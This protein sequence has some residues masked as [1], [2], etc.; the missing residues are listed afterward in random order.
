MGTASANA[1][2][3]RRP[4]VKRTIS[5]GGVCHSIQYSRV[6]EEGKALCEREGDTCG[7]YS[8]GSLCLE[9]RSR[10]CVISSRRHPRSAGTGTSVRGEI[11]RC[12]N[13]GT[14]NKLD[15]AGRR[16][17]VKRTSCTSR[18]RRNITSDAGDGMIFTLRLMSAGRHT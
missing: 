11:S 2:K 7:I 13:F 4:P 17:Q 15:S 18:T 8:T 1:E 14:A 16:I 3:K 10:G 5:E 6:A 9:V 12:Q